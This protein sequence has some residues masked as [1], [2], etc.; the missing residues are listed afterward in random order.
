METIQTILSTPCLPHALGSKGTWAHLRENASG[1][2]PSLP[3]TP[4]AA[5]SPAGVLRFHSPHAVRVAP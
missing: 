3:E 5:C 2:D 4:P 1:V